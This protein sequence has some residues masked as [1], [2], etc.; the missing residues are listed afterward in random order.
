M[1]A[2][3]EIKLIDCLSALE[4]GEALAEVLSR[5]PDDAARLRP[6]LQVA[7]AL[8][9]SRIEPSQA[10]RLASRE[11]F[12]ARAAAL[13]GDARPRLGWL[14]WLAARPRAVP[15]AMT[16]LAVVAIAFVV[17]SAGIMSVS[18]SALPGDPLYGVKRAVEN[19]RL[20]LAT[21]TAHGTLSAQFG[22]ERLDEVAALLDAGREAEVEFEGA[23]ESIQPEAWLVAGLVVRVNSA[24]R[25]A[26]DPQVGLRAGV[27]GRTLD[28][29][30]I[31]TSITVEPGEPPEPA[32]RPTPEPE[33][34]S[35]PE[36]ETTPTPT[37]TATQTTGPTVTPTPTLP[38]ATPTLSP[39]SF[40]GVV[41]AIGAESWTISGLAVDVNADTRI[42]AGIVVG[43]RVQVRGQRQADGKL[44]ATHIERIDDGGTG[45]ANENQNENG[46][47]NDNTNQ[48]G[49][50]NEN[51]NENQNDNENSND[52]T[53]QNENGNS[54]DNSNSNDN[55]N[56]NDN[57]NTN[58]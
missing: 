38:T 4:R 34:T 9:A 13:R 33:P 7:A 31:A 53:N 32:P 5:Y 12:L 40:E 1:E 50:A 20:S 58:D 46:N 2:E 37:R 52:N 39:V 26:G 41:E 51:E 56:G 48:N 27:Q 42:D 49:N 15:R 19:L 43:T 22:Q 36:P 16:S 29:M 35:T 57:S 25:I 55:G 45:N 3:L 14:A 8:P 28:G 47:T 11:A 17:F 44:T 30:L 18:A 23:I 24:T 21:D 6:M 10:A 54:N